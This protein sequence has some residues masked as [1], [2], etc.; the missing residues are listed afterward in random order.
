MGAGV[1][2]LCCVCVPVLIRFWLADGSIMRWHL[3]NLFSESY[4]DTLSFD[5][6]RERRCGRSRPCSRAILGVLHAAKDA[7]WRMAYPVDPSFD[8]SFAPS[9]APSFTEREFPCSVRPG[10]EKR[11]RARL[12]PRGRLA[13]QAEDV[14]VRWT[15]VR[16]SGPAK[17]HQGDFVLVTR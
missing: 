14:L 6:C 1:H 7:V 13:D 3:K 11:P 4:F 8:P 15:R 10:G 12:V 17:D 2:V 5:R 9:F 16:R